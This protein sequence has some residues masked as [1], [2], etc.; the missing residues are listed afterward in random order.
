MLK[1]RRAAAE[2]KASESAVKAEMLETRLLI[3]DVKIDS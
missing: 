2:E 1:R 3:E